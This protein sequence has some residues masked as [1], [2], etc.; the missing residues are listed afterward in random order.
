M[1]CL[2]SSMLLFSGCNDFLEINDDPNNPLVVPL[3]QLL[4]S[5]EVDMT[6]A[7]G[8]SSGGL[9]SV[10]STYM[11]QFVQRG[12]EL[13]D[14]G[15]GGGDFGVITPWTVVYSMQLMDLEFMKNLA[16]EEGAT[17]YLGVGQIIEA[18]TYSILVDVWGDIPFS[19]AALGTDNLAPKYDLGENVYPQLFTLLDDAIANLASESTNSPSND[20][21]FYGGDL[22]K[23]RKL[24][25]TL[26]LKLY[27]Q[28]RLVQNV[29]SE[30]NALIAEGDLI[31]ADDDFE[32]MH[33][34]TLT[35]DDRNPGWVQ[36]YTNGSPQ[37]YMSPF[38]YEIMTNQNTFN[39]RNYGGVINTTDPRV[40]YYFYNQLEEGSGDSD[41]QNKCSYCPSKSGSSFL[42]IYAFSFNIDPNEGFDQATSQTVGGLYPF[43]GAFDDGKGGGVSPTGGT[44]S[45]PLRLLTYCA[46]KYI[47]AE[48][49]LSGDATGDARVEF[50]EALN[51]SFAEVN[52][53]AANSADMAPELDQ[54]DI[55]TYVDA[56]LAAYDAA[57][58]DGKLEHIIT[59]KWLASFGWGVDSYT[60]YRR[61]G[62]PVLHD[63]NTDNVSVTKRGR[64]FPFSFP[65][66]TKNLSINASAP[67][68]K[69]VTSSAAKPFWMQ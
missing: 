28:V 31:S 39:H 30:V 58:D 56:V 33:G 8:N 49:I 10:T 43:G 13:N 35:P 18:Y 23:W 64:E 65:W 4:P 62:Y 26:K 16:I 67:S 14:Y 52:E 27:N 54:A 44:P 68:Q 61:T 38:F 24:A 7:L 12:A 37:Y 9:S 53:A 3:S 5:I 25:K 41:A 57:D 47:Q 36:E 69:L 34:T 21:L 29:S 59:Q 15:I 2:T 66:V 45:A 50:E 22:D 11:H 55:D 40:P 20:D 32:M 17:H 48:L 42:S 60:D 1:A 51:A 46:L 63:G 6:G 19:E